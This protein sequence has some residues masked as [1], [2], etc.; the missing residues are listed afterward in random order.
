VSRLN[1]FDCGNDSRLSSD[2]GNNSR[3]SSNGSVSMQKS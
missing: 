3:L 2:Y 1:K